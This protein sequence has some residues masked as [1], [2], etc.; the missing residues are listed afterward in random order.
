ML[1][2]RLHGFDYLGTYAY[3]LTLCAF[4]RLQR[5]RSARVADMVA[6]TFLTTAMEFDFDVLAYCIMPD[7]A[8]LL[9]QGLTPSAALRPFVTAIKQR[10]GYAFSRQTGDRLWQKGYFERTL[11]DDE[12]LLCVAR[13]IEANP[14]RAG[15]VDSIGL[16]PHVGGRLLSPSRP[17]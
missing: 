13:Y 2:P 4:S 14:V 3:S 6:R 12:D 10:S 9:A 16:W 7:H 8:H 5:F 1:P 15:L 11:R 17:G